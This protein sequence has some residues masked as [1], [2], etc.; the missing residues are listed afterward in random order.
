MSQKFNH[1]PE[2]DQSPEANTLFTDLTFEESAAINGGFGFLKKI[3]RS[4]KNAV[5]AIGEGAS[6]FLLNEMTNVAKNPWGFATGGQKRDV[7]EMDT[8]SRKG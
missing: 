5:R 8:W 6:H 1:T 4:I 3:G 2:V 7:T